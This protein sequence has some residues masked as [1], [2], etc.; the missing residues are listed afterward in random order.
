MISPIPYSTPHLAFPEEI[1][2]TA[3]AETIMNISASNFAF[4][5]LQRCCPNNHNIS[6][7]LPRQTRTVQHKRCTPIVISRAPIEDATAMFPSLN[8]LRRRHTCQRVLRTTHKWRTRQEANE[9]C[10]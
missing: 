3:I 8:D 7:S 2:N 9:N 6:I 1:P 5:P 10:F 4:S